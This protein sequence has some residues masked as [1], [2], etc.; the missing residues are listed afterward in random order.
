MRLELTRRGAYAIRAVLA[1]AEMPPDHVLSAARIARQRRIPSRFLPQVMADLVHAGL[2]EARVGRSGGY[3]LVRPASSV[4]LLDVIEAVEGDARRQTCVLRGEPCGSMSEPCDVHA[5]F[6]A[7][8]DALIG[9]L[10]ATTFSDI[11][12]GRSRPTLELRPD[13]M[14]A[15]LPGAVPA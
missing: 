12:E 11:A 5:V 3:R 9:E 13:A 8:Q 1:L 6:A 2:V 15:P 7:A 10:A 4:T 14:P